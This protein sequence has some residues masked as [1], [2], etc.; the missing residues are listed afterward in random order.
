MSTTSTKANSSWREAVEIRL[1]KLQVNDHISVSWIDA[2]QSANVPID[3]KQPKI[4]NHAIE[5]I[6]V[7]EGKFLR[8]QD[9]DSYHDPHLLI[10]KDTADKQK[11]TIQSIPLVLVREIELFGK[12][13]L[14]QSKPSLSGKNRVT[15]HYFDGIV[16][17]QLSSHT[18]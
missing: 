12:I 17:H 1:K 13:Q 10:L 5:T 2:S 15:I 3:K 4:P 8:I 18:E 11:A 14:L 7:S 16:K 6:V 9:G